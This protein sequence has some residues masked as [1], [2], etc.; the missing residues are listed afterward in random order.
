M[1]A[2]GATC[3]VP[4]EPD[5]RCPDFEIP[6]E[7]PG[8]PLPA[9]GVGCCIEN[10]CGVDGQLFGGGCIENDSARTMLGAMQ[11]IGALL[12]DG[13]PPARGCDEVLEDGGEVGEDGGN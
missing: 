4:A 10:K 8:F 12:V 5:T 7:I 9:V 6:I 11:P 1:T 13:V 2:D 3:N